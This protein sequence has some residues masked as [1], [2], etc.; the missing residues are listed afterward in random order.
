MHPL[1]DG[2]RA[3]NELNVPPALGRAGAG[4]TVVEGKETA[5]RRATQAS[6]ENRVDARKLSRRGRHVLGLLADGAQE[7][8]LGEDS[9][10]VQLD[11]P[12]AHLLAKSTAEKGRQ[13]VTHCRVCSGNDI[14]PLGYMSRALTKTLMVS[15]PSMPGTQPTYRPA[16]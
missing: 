9:K 12:S 6:L 4:S 16:T 7:E 11:K 10:L 2:G 3:V 1:L 15:S 8:V 14:G 5:G 13:A